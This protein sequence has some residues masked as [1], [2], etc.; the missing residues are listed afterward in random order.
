MKYL[1]FISVFLLIFACSKKIKPVAAPENPPVVTIPEVPIKQKDVSTANNNWLG[2]F[3]KTK[4][5]PFSNFPSVL[6][7]ELVFGF[8]RGACYGKC[9]S[10]EVKIYNDGFVGYYG[11]INIDKIGYFTGKIDKKQ[12]DYLV[13]LA[14][15]YKMTGLNAEYPD[16]NKWIMDLPLTTTYVALKDSKKLIITNH[17]APKMLIEFETKLES[18]I[19]GLE[20]KKVE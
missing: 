6:E 10:W 14:K 1:I 5:R 20:L 9:P 7:N 8:K 15:E 16:K 3:N 19:K 12:F 2:D 11:S 4:T 13:E 17:D 18:I